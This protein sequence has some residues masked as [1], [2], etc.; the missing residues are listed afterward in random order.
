MDVISR[1]RKDPPFK[2]VRLQRKDIFSVRDMTPLL[3]VRTSNATGDVRFKSWRWIR[4]SKKKPHV[5]QFRYTHC[6]VEP[7]KEVSYCKRG[8]QTNLWDFKLKQKFSENR[9]IN[10]AK[11]KDLKRLCRYLPLIAALFYRRVFANTSAYKATSSSSPTSRTSPTSRNSPTSRTSPTS[12]TSPTSP[13]SPTSRTSPPSH[14]ASSN[15]TSS[16]VHTSGDADN[17]SSDDADNDSSGD[18]DSSDD[19]DDNSSLSATD[20]DL[21]FSSDK[22]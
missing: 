8:N 1:A 20:Q 19:A 3:T 11:A 21:D 13:T 10:P 5:V 22:N 7:W 6:D 9:P 4:Y 14:R 15:K 16:R 17:S 2:V 12:S 18:D